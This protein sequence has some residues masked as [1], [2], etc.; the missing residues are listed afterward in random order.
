MLLLFENF[1][2]WRNKI[3]DKGYE[4]NGV[5]SLLWNRFRYRSVLGIS[6]NNRVFVWNERILVLMQ[7]PDRKNLSGFLFV[8]CEANLHQMKKTFCNFSA[9]NITLQS[10]WFFCFTKASKTV[11]AKL[12]WRFWRYGKNNGARQSPRHPRFRKNSSVA[13][14][15]CALRAQSS[16]R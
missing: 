3:L 10:E 11:M 8:Y 13:P 9:K 1:Q 16:C 7:K 14:Q 6:D 15:S 4:R 5:M 2:S 12:L